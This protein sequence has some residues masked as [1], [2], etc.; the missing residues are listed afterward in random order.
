M[1]AC[2]RRHVLL[3]PRHLASR[4]TSSP[5]FGHHAHQRHALCAIHHYASRIIHITYITR[6]SYHASLIPAPYSSRRSR[7]DFRAAMS[8]VRCATRCAA[9]QRGIAYQGTAMSDA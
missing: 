7:F 3:P 5:I 4:V 9:C 8:R 6:H 2:D 1:C